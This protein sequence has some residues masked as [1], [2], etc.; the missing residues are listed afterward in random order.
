MPFSADV[1]RVASFLSSPEC[2]SV[3][4]LTGAGV[5]TASGIPDFRSPSGMYATLPVDRLTATSAQREAI[6]GDPTNVV[7]KDMFFANAFPYLEIRRPFILGTRDRTWH[8]TLAHRFA[9]LLHRKTKKLTRVFTQNIDGLDYQTSLPPEKIVS[10]HGS[11][12]RVAC[13]GCG[14][15]TCVD[16]FCDDVQENIKDVYGVDPEAPAKSSPITCAACHRPLVKPTTVLFGGSL[17]EEFF[18]RCRVDLPSAD[19][20]II[21][22]T[23]LVVSPANSVVHLVAATTTRVVINDEPVG[24]DLGIRYDDDNDDARDLFLRG[25]CDKTFLALMGALDWREALESVDTDPARRRLYE[26]S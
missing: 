4:M 10:V 11:I 1:R 17:P 24:E 3:V 7:T 26:Q 6:R 5:S 13:E 19:L 14:T 25:D 22:G 2:R 8:P 9:E 18:R 12:G 23:S 16:M 20:L 15:S 21:A